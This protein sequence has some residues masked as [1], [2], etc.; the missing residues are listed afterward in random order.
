MKILIT[1]DWHFT[2]KQPGSRRDNIGD[3]FY[4]KLSEIFHLANEWEVSAI[5]QPGDFFDSHKAN[6]ETKATLVNIINQHFLGDTADL[7]TIYGQHDL[8]YH[9]SN[10]ANTP[11]NL[12]EKSGYVTILKHV[13]PFSF[14]G[15]IDFYGASWFEDIPKVEHKDHFNILVMH[16]MVVDEKLWQTQDDCIKGHIFLKTKKDYNL[17][18]SG[19]NHTTFTAQS[20]DRFL[21]NAGCLIRTNIGQENH[22]PCVFLF[23][24]DTKELKQYRLHIDP[25]NEVIKFDEAKKEKESNEIL[26]QYSRA[27]KSNTQLT[28]INYRKNVHKYIK[29][30]GDKV[31]PGMQEFIKKTFERAEQK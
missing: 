16:K 14:P 9:Q 5:V 20:G 21:V 8:R 2:L 1:G 7:L 28:G 19:D 3:V 27:L 10:V 29:E 4:K 12:L 23:D 11:L 13:P 6:D 22:H 30:N 25:F 24:T 15:G 18:I 31:T 17:V 26:Q